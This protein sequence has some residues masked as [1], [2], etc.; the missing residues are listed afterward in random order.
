MIVL[1]LLIVVVLIGLTAA[2]VLGRIGGFMADP[3]SSRAFSGLPDDPAGSL[4]SADIERVHFEQA[5]RGYRMDQV[6]E[7]IGALSARLRELETEIGSWRSQG[8]SHD[9]PPADASTPAPGDSSAG[10]PG[11]SNEPGIVAV[12]DNREP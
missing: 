8:V 3:T 2:A 6:D 9:S 1:F 7:V 5:L 12:T 4:S 11:D 10:A